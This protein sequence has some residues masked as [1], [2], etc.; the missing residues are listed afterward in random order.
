MSDKKAGR[1]GKYEGW[2]TKD[3]LLRVQGWARDG[4]SNEQI[5]HNMG[6]NK[7]TL[8]TWQKRFPEFSDALK[9]SKEVVDREVE[10]I[11]VPPSA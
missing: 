8:Y 5:A 2:L 3:G 1:P 7:D 6:I 11:P 4:L 10:N 9:K